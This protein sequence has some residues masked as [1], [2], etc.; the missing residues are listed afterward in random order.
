MGI[1]KRVNSEE[2]EKLLK[3][4][5]ELDAEIKSLRAEVAALQSNQNSLRGLVNRRGYQQEKEEISETETNIKP[6]VLLSP[7][8]IAI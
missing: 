7:N 5:I 8:G 4:F 1:F 6:K 2:Y 3:K